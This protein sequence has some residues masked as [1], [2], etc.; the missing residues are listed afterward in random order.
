MDTSSAGQGPAAPRAGRDAGPF[1]SALRLS[2]EV[3]GAVVDAVPVGVA[4]FAEDGRCAY[5]NSHGRRLLGAGTGEEAARALDGAD[6]SAE[7]LSPRW[8]GLRFHEMVSGPG[9]GQRAVVF[10]AVADPSGHERRLQGLSWAVAGIMASG[11]LVGA[12]NAI[13]SEVKDDLRLAAANI[14]LRRDA[15]AGR[16][17]IVG[18]AGFLGTP[19]ERTA[20]MRD[21]DALGAEFKHR[22]AM[23]A[24]RLVVVPH[25]YASVMRDPRW[26]P[27]HHVLA[28]VAWDGFVAAPLEARGRVVGTL[29]AFYPSDLA[30]PPD[31]EVQRLA[32]VAD[33]AAV[34]VDSADLLARTRGWAVAQERDRRGRELHGGAGPIR[35]ATGREVHLGSI[36]VGQVMGMRTGLGALTPRE[37]EVLGLLAE[38][39]TNQQ[40][41]RRL[42]ITERTARTHVS[43]LLGKLRLGSRTQAA[44]LAQQ[45]GVL[46]PAPP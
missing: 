23:R 17:E 28:T 11:S 25:R 8:P 20:R 13:A 14:V 39:R 43:N 24:R 44:L 37:I 15:D 4:A 45:E 42:A 2:P 38:G 32:A 1:A 12:L 9:G 27:A 22:E 18:G 26:A 16:A 36:A 3:L 33:Q 35:A 30:G 29:S 34:A 21:C 31:A 46:P 6:G 40:I 19:E 7:R 10:Q 41:A 5:V